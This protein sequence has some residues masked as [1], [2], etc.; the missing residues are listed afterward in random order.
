VRRI[1]KLRAGGPTCYIGMCRNND[2]ATLEPLRWKWSGC[3][4]R[5]NCSALALATSLSSQG[6][7]R[8]LFVGD[9]TMEQLLEAF[10]C[11]LVRSGCNATRVA[12]PPQR[13]T[14]LDFVNRS[15][16]NT[17][18]PTIGPSP[19]PW[20]SV[21]RKLIIS[22]P[23]SGSQQRLTLQ[24]AQRFHGGNLLAVKEVKCFYWRRWASNPQMNV[25]MKDADEFCEKYDPQ[26]DFDSPT[27]YGRMFDDADAIIVNQG[28]HG[29]KH[30]DLLIRTVARSTE[31][32]SGPLAVWLQTLPQHFPTTRATTGK[33]CPG[34]YWSR[35][36][37]TTVAP[38]GAIHPS[39]TPL[40]QGIGLSNAKRHPAEMDVFQCLPHRTANEPAT[41]HHIMAERTMQQELAAV[42]TGRLQVVPLFELLRSRWDLH[43]AWYSDKAH[44]FQNETSNVK[45][46]NLVMVPAPGQE[47]GAVLKRARPEGNS[48]WNGE[49]ADCTHFCFTPTLFA[50]TFGL[51]REGLALAAAGSGRSEPR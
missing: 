6:R 30:L 21:D 37:E 16:F 26:N 41:C 24:I 46:D 14:S 51:I 17:M 15:A 19:D 34:D 36:Y 39:V 23:V 43:G 44:Q 50:A 22:C 11:A 20:G 1:N 40:D 7:T 12:P 31:R 4:G 49:G 29:S 28:L 33:G 25:T 47:G 3:N 38:D 2:I 8:L 35:W 5:N 48:H 27:Q 13:T 32:S 18:M 9:S 45:Q 10:V 42:A